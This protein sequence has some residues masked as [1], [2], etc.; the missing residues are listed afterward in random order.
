MAKRKRQRKLVKAALPKEPSV[1]LLRRHCSGKGVQFAS[2]AELPELDVIIGQERATQAI[3]FGLNIESFGYNI[4]AMGP[5]GAGKTTTIM[6]YLQHKAKERPVPDDWAYVYNFQDPDSPH[7]LRIPSGR[8]GE[9][10][11]DVRK[12][13]QSVSEELP[14]AYEG[15]KYNETR[16]KIVHDLEG[17]RK[18]LVAEMEGYA[19]E[20]N[21][22]LASTPMGIVLAPLKDGRP[23]KAEEYNTLPDEEKKRYEAQQGEVQ[24]RLDQIM[25][26]IGELGQIARDRLQ[27]LDQQIADRMVHHLFQ[28]LMEKYEDYPSITDWLDE[29]RQDM[30]KNIALLRKVLAG[31]EKKDES[32]PAPTIMPLR[33]AAISPLQR[34]SV[35]VIV[36]HEGEEGAPVILE[37]NPTYQNIM[38]R[39][40]HKAQ[41]GMLVT[42]FTLIRSGALH[43]ANGGYLVLDVQTVLR[44]PFS[45]DALKRALRMQEIRPEA[46]EQ[47][48]GILSISGLTPEPIPL[49][50][51]VVL[52]GNPLIY[53][54]LYAYD[55]EFQKLFKV[56]ADFVPEMEWNDENVKQIASYI[57]MRCDEEKLPHFSLEAVAAIIEYSSRQV[58][59][60]RKLTTRFAHV[61]DMVREAAFWAQKSGHDLVLAGD[62]QKAID[63]RIH[64]ANYIEER[65]REM[66][67]RD[68]IKLD[69][70]GEKVGQV[71]GLAVLELGDYMFG[72]PSRITARTYLGQAGVINIEREAHLS[73]SVHDKGVLI[74]GGYLGGKYAQNQPLSLSATITFEQSYEGVEGDSA[75]S[76]ELY[77]ILSSLSNLPIKQNIAVTGSINQPG[78]I[79]AI[80]GVTAKVEGFFDLCQ[81]KG[82][83]GDQGVIIPESNVEHLMLRKDVVDAVEKGEFH[84]Y[85]VRTVDEGISIL[86]GVAAG[87]RGANGKYP[88]GTVNALVEARLRQMA[89]Q[90]RSFG[91][92]VKE[93]KEKEVSARGGE[94]EKRPPAPPKTPPDETES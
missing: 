62:V 34:Y 65:L 53:Y 64:R 75:S 33:G 87:E 67:I 84:I 94:P 37:P 13:L 46:P 52:I 40:E 74:L 6:R 7:A 20:R 90:L 45:W 83:T 85:P 82:L 14:Q 21:F 24:E 31:E 18:Q 72:R 29:V 80:G 58:G 89:L 68:I 27:E 1:S 86:T 63:E 76:S 47:M 78:E 38:G 23:L 56:R 91:R 16:N 17:E 48:L 42:D 41:M 22:A 49:D 4:Y 79:Q 44:Q 30:V 70:S 25:R 55:E 15:D 88:A 61:L 43:R 28:A 19:K 73:G 8:G 71:N 39:Q 10:K 3:E 92:P 59:D 51:K 5:A 26:K 77:A 11:E 60:Q 35:N 50:V 81:E 69:V 32:G 54:L 2:T 9:V 12:L 93:T 57:R 66:T 36:S